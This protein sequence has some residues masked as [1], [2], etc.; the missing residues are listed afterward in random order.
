MVAPVNENIRAREVRLINESGEQVG[1]VPLQTALEQ[2]RQSNLDLVQL[3]GN[4]EPP[5]C[6]VMDYGKYLYEIKKQKALA[7]KKQ[8][9]IQV[10]EI[11]FRP[12]TEEGDYQVK[13]RNLIRFL[14]DGNKTKVSLRYRG[15]E[16][17]HQELGMTLLKR[18]EA[19]LEQYGVV[20]QHPKMEGRQ[21][22]MVLAP[23]KKKVATAPSDVS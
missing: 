2:A 13:L 14:E 1:I 11:K 5:V 21:L 22:V 15:R 3:G 6:K 20:E 8:T 23:K 18:I 17:A 12:G 9:I 19:D 10:K 7:K 4:A 16:M